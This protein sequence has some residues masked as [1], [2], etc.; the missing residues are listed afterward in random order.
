MKTT[1]TPLCLCICVCAC[2]LGLCDIFL[3][4]E[5]INKLIC[6]ILKG[7]GTIQV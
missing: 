1:V 7:V 4:L 2:M 6:K 5:G 3:S